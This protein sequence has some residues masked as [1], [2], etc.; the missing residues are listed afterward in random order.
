MFIT[1][2]L[3]AGIIIGI[4]ISEIISARRRR[5]R[6]KASGIPKNM[7]KW[8]YQRLHDITWKAFPIQIQNDYNRNTLNKNSEDKKFFYHNLKYRNL[9]IQVQIRDYNE[10]KQ[11]T[12]Y[13]SDKD[14]ELIRSYI[15]GIYTYILYTKFCDKDLL[16]LLKK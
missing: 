9:K 5:K 15:E 3:A 2:S 1:W 4:I 14:E 10:Y 7:K 8:V 12:F 16:T 6:R 13:V 11:W